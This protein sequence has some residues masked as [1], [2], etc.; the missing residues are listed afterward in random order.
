MTHDLSLLILH[1]F[2][3]SHDTVRALAPMTERLRLPYQIPWLRGHGTQPED[4]RG[5]RWRDWYDDARES[6]AAMHRA[7]G[8]VVVCGHSMGG[9]VALHLAADAPDQV[10]GVITIAAALRIANPLGR[11]MPLL[12]RV[13]LMR[14]S[15]LSFGFNDK[16]LAFRNT[17]YPA[18]PLD[19][20]AS[21]HRYAPLVERRLAQVR[22]PLLVLHSRRDRTVRPEAAEIIHARAGSADKQIRWFERTGHQMLLDCEEDAVVAAIEAWLTRLREQLR[23]GSAAPSATQAS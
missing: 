6:L 10:A 7:H 19:A 2:T 20:A 22:A 3:S 18:F 13:R 8:P 17:N 16:S 14:P 12:G 15:D 11:L 23:A 21:L 9:L 4:L 5:V 1:G